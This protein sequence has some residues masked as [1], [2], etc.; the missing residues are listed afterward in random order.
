MLDFRLHSEGSNENPVWG[1]AFRHKV[2]VTKA[3]DNEMNKRPSKIDVEFPDGKIYTF[4]IRRCFWKGCYEFVDAQVRDKVS[5]K[6][7][8][9]VNP[10]K[11]LAIDT[12]GY[13]I[14]TKGE[15]IIRVQVVKRNQLLRV[16]TFK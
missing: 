16:A 12:L 5:G 10:I 13:G 7:L 9:K 11:S 1:I 2:D 4:G 8:R 14:E 3:I 6:P 15:C